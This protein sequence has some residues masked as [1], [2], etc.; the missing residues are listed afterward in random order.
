MTSNN[1]LSLSVSKS[2]YGK[3]DS[4]LHTREF[5]MYKVGLRLTCICDL[6]RKSQ[7]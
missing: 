1:I 5:I 2:G 4:K 7:A 3:Q 6:F